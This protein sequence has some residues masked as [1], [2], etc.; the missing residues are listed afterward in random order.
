M[1][2]QLGKIHPSAGRWTDV[3]AGTVSTS[4]PNLV[5]TAPHSNNSMTF[6]LVSLRAKAT[7][8]NDDG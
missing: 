4:G 1:A 8:Q 2:F 7:W 5:R 6:C 3:N